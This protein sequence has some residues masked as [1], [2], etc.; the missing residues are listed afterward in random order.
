MYYFMIY[1]N[2]GCIIKSFLYVLSSLCCQLLDRHIRHNER[3][4]FIYLYTFKHSLVVVCLLGLI[5][6]ATVFPIKCNHL[7][8]ILSSHCI[9][10]IYPFTL[11]IFQ[12]YLYISV[13]SYNCKVWNVWQWCN[14]FLCSCVSYW[15][16]SQYIIQWYLNIINMIRS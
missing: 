11:Y 2:I 3:Y 10:M 16:T 6:V 4:L 9:D 15:Y 1:I 14:H 12:L 5:N 13:V 7:M 8:C